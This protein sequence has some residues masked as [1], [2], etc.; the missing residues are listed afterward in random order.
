MFPKILEKNS[1]KYNYFY[2]YVPF[3]IGFFTSFSLPPYNYTFINFITFTYLLILLLSAKM[4]ECGNKIFFFIGWFFGLGFFLSSLYWI[5]I[6]LTHDNLFKILIPFSL[7]IIPSFL[8]TFY[9]IATLIL[10]RFVTPKISFILIFSLVFAFIEYLRGN[11]LGGFPWNLFAYS[12][13]WSIDVIQCIKIVGTYGF[14]LLSITIFSFPFIFFIKIKKINI[15][16]SFTI[17]F[18]IVYVIWIFGSTISPKKINSD[19]NDF[20]IKIVSPNI[21]LHEFFKRNNDSKT[22]NELIKLSNPDKKLKT[23]IRILYR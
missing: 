7:I 2:Y 13:S 22:I 9:G 1:K 23:I 3:V 16:K 14:N 6:S 21:E 10:K 11:I 17:L 4:T 5:S 12:W 15:I 20:T 8:A 19:V 18:T